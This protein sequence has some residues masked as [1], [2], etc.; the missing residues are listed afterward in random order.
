MSIH[1]WRTAYASVIGSSHQKN[2]TCCQ[3]AGH[4]RIVK[5]IDGSDVLLA[6]ASD[7]AGSAIRSEIGAQLTVESFLMQFEEVVK[8]NPL[9]TIDR[10]Y[11]L[12]WLQNLKDIIFEKA[13]QE[14]FS[15]KE[16]ACT[17]LAAIVGH[18][19]AIF[20]QIGDGAIA[21]SELGS[22][23]YGHMFW[24]QHGEFANQ[25]NFLIQKNIEEILEFAF[26]QQ[27]FESISIFTDGI[28]R[29]VLDFADQAVYSPALRPIFNWLERCEPSSDESPSAALIA[30]L[31]S[32]FINSRTDDDKTLVMATRALP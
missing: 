15:P 5:T 7:G 26:V 18:D 6:V 28:E 14:S 19:S 30:Y 20:F 10:P 21:I 12:N 27:T 24:P 17:I 31:N 3:D 16:Y 1:K 4:C 2:G 32:D 11:V 13:E 29:L 22:V 8:K 25:T 23:D 9:S